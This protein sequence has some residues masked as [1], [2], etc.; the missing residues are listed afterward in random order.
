MTEGPK[1]SRD[2]TRL[3]WPWIFT[4]IYLGV[5]AGK[6]YAFGFPNFIK[7]E[8]NLLGE[9]LAGAFAPLAFFWPLSCNPGN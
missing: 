2:A 4:T 5:I 6:V 8:P 7:L 9:F 3:V 1:E